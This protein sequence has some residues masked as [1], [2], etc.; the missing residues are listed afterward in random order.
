MLVRH[1]VVDLGFEPA[2][3]VR[4]LAVLLGAPPPVLRMDDARVDL[5]LLHI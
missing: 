1:E 3:V 4:R 2:E 5:S